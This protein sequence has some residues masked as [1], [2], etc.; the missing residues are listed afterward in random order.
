[1][2][3]YVIFTDSCSDLPAHLAKK[4]Q[5]EVIPFNYNIDYI[6]YENHL[7]HSELDAGVF[8]SLLRSGKPAST[9]LVNSYTYMEAFEPFLK[10]G[11]DILYLCFSSA[12]SGSYGQ[13]RTA[14]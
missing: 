3:D 2:S 14:A 11:K 9:A 6:D 12:L 10:E 1:M 8:Y 5:L 13:A 4:L 7:D